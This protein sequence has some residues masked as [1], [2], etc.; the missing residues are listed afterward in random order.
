MEWA[1][2]AGGLDWQM[3]ERIPFFLLFYVLFYCFLLF[4]VVIVVVVVVVVVAFNRFVV[5]CNSFV[6]K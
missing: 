6:F 4:V 1:G 3:L 2:R 5:T